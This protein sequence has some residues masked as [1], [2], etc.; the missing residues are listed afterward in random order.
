VT[1]RL[2]GPDNRARCIAPNKTA[3]CIAPNKTAR[4]IAPNKTARCIAPP[5]LRFTARFRRFARRRIGV[6]GTTSS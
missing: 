2:T 3:R 6:S 1:G 4:W 5:I